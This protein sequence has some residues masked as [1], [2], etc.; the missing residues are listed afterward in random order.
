MLVGEG[1][2]GRNPCD[3]VVFDGEAARFCKI[4]QNETKKVSSLA[5]VNMPVDHVRT[6]LV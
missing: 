6:Y 5:R 3:G 1:F 4:T 2:L